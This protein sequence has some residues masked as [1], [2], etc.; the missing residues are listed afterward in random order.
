MSKTILSMLLTGALILLGSQVGVTQSQEEFDAI[1]REIQDLKKN[2]Q[3]LQKDLDTVK[4][5][6]RGRRRPEP[7]KQASLNVA[8]DPYKGER[9]VPLVLVDFSDYQ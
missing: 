6:L 3:R 1:K 8:D 7:F 2:Q 9:N 4:N 5:A